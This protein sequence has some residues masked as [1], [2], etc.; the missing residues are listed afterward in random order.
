MAVWRDLLSQLFYKPP[1]PTASF[2]D[3]TVIVT[4]ANTG[5][6]KEAAIHFVRLG[7][8]K[9]VLAVRPTPKKEVTGEV[10]KTNIKAATGKTVTTIF[11]FA[12]SVE[13]ELKRLDVVVLNAGM[14]RQRFEDNESTITGK[15]Y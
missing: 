14:S 5:L 15:C 2:T 1:P 4:G 10:A 6:E 8:A 3:K 13:K 7:A 11:A 12:A 9:D